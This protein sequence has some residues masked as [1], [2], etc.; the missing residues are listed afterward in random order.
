MKVSQVMRVICA[1]VAGVVPLTVFGFNSLGPPAGRTGAPGEGSTL[2]CATCHG[3]GTVNTQ[4]G[5]VRAT[6][7][8]GATYTP[9]TPITITVTVADPTNTRFGFEMTARLES[10][11]ATAQA[12]RFTT[13]GTGVGVICSDDSPRS[14]SGNCPVS[15]PL[16]FIQQTQTA[17]A[18]WT[19]T[20]TPPATAV[21]PVHFYVAGNAVNGN[22]R[23]DNGDRV[24]TADYVL[25][26]AAACAESAPRITGVIS[27]GAFGARTDFSPGTWLEIYG[28]NFS[29]VTKEWAGSD[30]NGSNAPTSLDNVRVKINGQSAFMRFLSPGQIN[31]QAPANANGALNVTVEN[32]NS[33]S[34]PANLN[35]VTAAPG[36]LA[37]NGKLVAFASDNTLRA[38]R[39]GETIVAYGIGFGATT[40]AVAPGTI[41][42][43]A[44]SL[45]EPLTVTIGGVQLTPQ[46][47]QYA[48]LSPNFVGLYQFN[49]IVPTVPDGDQPITMRV[50]SSS[51]TQTLTVAVRR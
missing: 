20:W 25:T 7:S 28:S 19:F 16:E 43:V 37:S 33:I 14:P 38:A 29:T 23:P 44:N 2:A 46:Q 10:S 18:P 15:A 47:I 30:F 39:P 5:S 4:G 8:G 49:L 51:L 27:A 17:T 45:A 11:P 40:P 42:G 1:V 36:M 9:G 12:G 6:F 34:P 3:N 26:P 22:F 48:G 21:G 24:Y 31:V 13:Q 35:Q 41:V 50:G 32:C